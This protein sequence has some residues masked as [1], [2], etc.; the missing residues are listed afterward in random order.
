MASGRGVWVR[1]VGGE[2]GK[3]WSAGERGWDMVRG[4]S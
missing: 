4:L 2:C 3:L 1:V